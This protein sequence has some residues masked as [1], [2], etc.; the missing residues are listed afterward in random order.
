MG[1]A[2]QEEASHGDMDHRLGDIE[3]PLKITDE[4]TPAD[5]PTECALDHPPARQ[6][7]EARFAVDAT[8][9]LDDE[10]EER[11]LVEQL[12]PVVGAIG[13]QVLNPRPTFADGVQNRRSL[14][15]KSISA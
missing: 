8:H 11:R 13:K 10:V 2:A 9:D 7:L 12:R 3:T 4:A 5:Q 6:H 14:S 15:L 1:D